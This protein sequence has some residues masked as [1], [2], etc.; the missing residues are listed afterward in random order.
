MW[1]DT[2]ARE[3]ARPW[4]RGRPDSI[5][6]GLELLDKFVGL[7]KRVRARS[8][9][10][11]GGARTPENRRR[12]LPAMPPSSN[13]NAAAAA[14]VV[15]FDEIDASVASAAR[16][17][18]YHWCRDGVTAQLLACRTGSRTRRVVVATTNDPRLDRAYCGRL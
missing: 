16:S 2:L 5:V 12:R 18:G 7:W 4:R 14:N 13:F 9:G 17:P 10:R 15:I 1:Q 11:T 8:S 6:N 3:L